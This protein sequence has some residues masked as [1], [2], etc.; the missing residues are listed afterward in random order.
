MDQLLYTIAQCCRITAI[1]RTKFYEL[2]GSNEIPIRKVGAK[3]LVSAADLRRWADQL[4]AVKMKGAEADP[5]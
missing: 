3:T 2:I 1:G 4:P 5:S